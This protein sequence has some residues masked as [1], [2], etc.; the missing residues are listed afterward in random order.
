MKTRLHWLR[1]LTAVL[2]SLIVPSSDSGLFAGDAKKAGLQLQEGDVVAL[3]GDSITSSGMYPRF[4][5]VYQLL[6]GPKM[7]VGFVNCG[8]W[9]E[10]AGDFP[11]S[12]DRDFVAAKPTVV[13]ICYGMNIGRG[14][15]PL[16]EPTLAGEAK[17]LKAIIEKFKAG[18]GRTVILGSPGCVDTN[19]H[20]NP[21]GANISLGQL[22]DNARK[23]AEETKS[24]FAD[25][26]TP[27]MEVMAKAQKKFGKEYAF[28]GGKGDGLHPG[29]AGHLVMAWVYLKALGYDGA[30]GTLTLEL[31][32]GQARA[33]D[34]HKILSFKGGVA[35]VESTRSP[36]C[37]LGDAK[38]PKN[39]T[40]A[41]STRSVMDLFPFNDD[42]NRLM[43]IVR[44]AKSKKLKIVWG[45]QVKEFDAIA[46]EKGINL[47]A[48][49]HDNPFSGP[50]AKT[51]GALAERDQCRQ[52]LAGKEFKGNPSILKRQEAALRAL[53]PVPVTHAIRVE[54][55]P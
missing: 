51:L 50:F 8:R 24:I 21:D 44:G 20:H 35:E 41:N 6:C 43:F 15:S 30:I 25:V 26:H 37:F 33:S 38:N 49:F 3:C 14:G 55:L 40:N 11:K 12:W 52:W 22:R 19:F 1:M 5:E 28:A 42:L 7:K 31:D 13:T 23:L 45:S 27:M 29:Q 36:F 47:A 53:A 9:G 48:E 10:N 18:G 2:M 39:D 32:K 34:G 54:E 4:V 16:K 17:A 46:L